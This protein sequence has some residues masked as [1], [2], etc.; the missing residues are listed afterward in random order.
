[1]EF[2][3]GK[4][5]FINALLGDNLLETGATPTTEAIE[6]VRYGKPKSDAPAQIGDY[7]REW[8][9][10]NT[11]S[12]GIAIVD[13]P[14]TGSVFRQH[15]AVAKQ[16]LHRADLVVFVLSAKRAFAETERLYLELAQGYGKKII[17]LVNQID[18]LEE[19]ELKEVEAF[20]RTQAK[21]LLHL[22]PPLFLISAK[23]ALSPDAKRRQRS[24]MSEIRNY[25]NRIFMKVPPAQQ[26][27]LAQLDLAERLAGKAR[28]TM[29]ARLR[30][31]GDDEAQAEQIRMELEAHAGQINERRDDAQAELARTFGNLRAR[32]EDFINENLRLTKLGQALDRE[33][34]RA[35][36]EAEVVGRAVDSIAAISNTYVN[37]L[38]DG[39]RI[40]WRGVLERLNKLDALVRAE[41]GVVDANTYAD[42]RAVLQ[43]AIY[44]A[45]ER[46][47]A[48]SDPVTVELIREQF[49]GNVVRLGA[50][51]TVALGGAVAVLVNLA[52]ALIPGGAVAAPV[53]IILGLPAA[54]GGG[55]IAAIYWR[56]M[57][58]DAKQRLNEQIDEIEATYKRTLN[59][60][61][62]RERSRLLQYGQQVLAPV[63]S[64]LRVL[65]ERYHQQDAKLQAFQDEIAR[66]RAEVEKA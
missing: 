13:T 11:G 5:S 26:K 49:R 10:P 9:H 35:K 37:A 51:T 34:L 20:V 55:A 27:L 30:L 21:E 46:L 17:M 43:E 24:G 25:L 14:G 3:A 19:R 60:L 59:D 32:G 29:H 38:V 64:Q 45:E 50:S 1:G 54:I 53:A 58:N 41:V 16:F 28:T 23:E 31:V 2:N 47:R 44:T 66:L 65:S 39:S 56:R 62:E 48:Y 7:L 15:E 6:L 42:Q 33:R 36:F 63:V 40:Y 57:T 61:T 4:S 8:R 52:A 12:P 18:L 22:E